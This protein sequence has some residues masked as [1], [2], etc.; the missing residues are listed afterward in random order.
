MFQHKAIKVGEEQV[1]EELERS[2]GEGFELVTVVPA[3]NP[4][5]VRFFWLFFKKPLSVPT[6]IQITAK[7]AC[8]A[9]E[10]AAKRPKL[11]VGDTVEVSGWYGDPIV[12]RIDKVG[13]A[14]LN[15]ID[16]MGASHSVPFDVQGVTFKKVS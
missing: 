12:L 15:G 5:G 16:A 2:S 14:S 9:I 1:V 6:S 8:E 10:R 7:K 3:P 11:K 13:P 4:F